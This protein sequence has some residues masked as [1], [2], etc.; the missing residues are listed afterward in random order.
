MNNMAAEN[1]RWCFRFMKFKNLRLGNA[2]LMGFKE[3]FGGC[4]EALTNRLSRKL[5]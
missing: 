5:F 2:G 1:G 4:R 3:N